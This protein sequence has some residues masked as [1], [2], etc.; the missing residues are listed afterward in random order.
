M[1][2]SSGAILERYRGGTLERASGHVWALRERVPLAVLATPNG[3]VSRAGAQPSPSGTYSPD[4][5]YAAYATSSET[6]T[7]RDTRDGTETRMKTPYAGLGRDYWVGW[8]GAIWSGSGRYFT[9]S[10][11]YGD[12]AR[13]VMADVP[14]FTETL[15]GEPRSNRTD[16]SW[17][18]GREQL[19]Y[20]RDG[21][22]ILYD[23]L[24]G[25]RTPLGPGVAP[26]FIANDLVVFNGAGRVSV[27]V[28]AD[29]GREVGRW[30]APP[31][32]AWSNGAA[33]RIVV[34]SGDCDVIVS[35]DGP[36]SAC[37]TR[38]LAYGWSPDGARLAVLRDEMPGRAALVIRAYEDGRER[39]LQSGLRSTPSHSCF[40]AEVY[41]STD[42]SRLVLLGDT[43][44]PGDG[45]GL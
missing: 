29:T 26:G 15:V 24:S 6:L 23:V 19:V 42:A 31:R 39:V 1:D 13:I 8:P 34:S 16:D 11:G 41:W 44:R 35:S 32:A 36:T 27:V 45:C 30:S 4:L 38:G 28:E 40:H 22:V 20:E 12:Q 21:L 25:V 5:R 33:Y 37:L 9:F 10:S 43:N 3:T 18:P 14:T 2:V 7:I 17:R